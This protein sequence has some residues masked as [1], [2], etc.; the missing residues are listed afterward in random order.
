MKTILPALLLLPFLAS[1][2]DSN[3]G[4]YLGDKASSHYSTL[5]QI[6]TKNVTKLVR[7]WTFHM[8]VGGTA[9]AGLALGWPVAVA[10]AYERSMR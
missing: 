4:T 7:A 9:A 10:P 8:N 6:D 3:W 5:K 2:A 1:A